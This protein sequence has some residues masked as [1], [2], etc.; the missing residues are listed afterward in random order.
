M[1]ESPI[2]TGSDVVVCYCDSDAT[3]CEAFLRGLESLRDEQVISSWQKCLVSSESAVDLPAN[4]PSQ[5]FLVLLS[6]E[7]LTTGFMQGK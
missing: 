4:K 2:A 6:P 7:F 5:V 3:Y 1:G